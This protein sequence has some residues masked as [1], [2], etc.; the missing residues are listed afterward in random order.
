MEVFL[1]Y[2]LLMK[3]A[4]LY[5]SLRL[6]F[7]PLMKLIFRIEIINKENILDDEGVVLCGNHT[8]F[9]DPILVGAATKRNVYFLAKNSLHKGVKRVFFKSVGTIPIDRSSKNPEAIN[10]SL[11]LLKNKKIVCVFPEGTIN[12]TEDLI[13]PFKFGAV[14]MAQKSNSYIVPF[15]ITGDYKPFRKSVKIEFSKPYKVKEDLIKEN[16]ILMKK[17]R[18]LIVKN[19]GLNGKE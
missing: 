14:S 6:I 11:E 5:K 19:G 3:D 2:N 16:N 17:V 15:S 18:K 4:I 7:T 8:S 9:L 13:M 10:K 12:K 1:W